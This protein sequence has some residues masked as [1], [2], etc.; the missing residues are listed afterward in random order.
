M[1]IHHSKSGER[2]VNWSPDSHGIIYIYITTTMDAS[3]NKLISGFLRGCRLCLW[4]SHFGSD[5]MRLITARGSQD[6][7][8]RVRSQL[9]RAT[10]SQIRSSEFQIFKTQLLADCVLD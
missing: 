3:K 1:K 4:E 5:V 2:Q 8:G 10:S 9:I 7:R 6:L